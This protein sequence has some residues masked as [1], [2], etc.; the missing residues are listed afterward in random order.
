MDVVGI[1]IDNPAEEEKI[2]SLAWRADGDFYNIKEIGDL[3]KERDIIFHT[4]AVQAV[5]HVPIDVK[6]MNVDLL[7]IS[8]HKLYGPKGIGALYVKKGVRLK[9]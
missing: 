1:N 5:C 9:A 6:D 8:S 7:S 4:D 3:A 2:R